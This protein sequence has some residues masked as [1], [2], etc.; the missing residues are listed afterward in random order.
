MKIASIRCLILAL[1]LTAIGGCGT[2]PPK[3]ES[4][5]GCLNL[6]SGGQYILTEE[7]TARAVTVTAAGPQADLKPHGHKHRV[8]ITG[9]RTTEQGR[10]VFKASAIQ[11]LNDTCS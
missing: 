2:S 1:V 3:S 4:R 9:I 11:H 10:E 5:T 8:T 6:R 7:K